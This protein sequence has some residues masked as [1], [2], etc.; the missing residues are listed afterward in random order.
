M[1]QRNHEEKEQE[2][3]LPNH[4]QRLPPLRID[5]SIVLEQ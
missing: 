2:V 5:I 1:R 4:S 3:F